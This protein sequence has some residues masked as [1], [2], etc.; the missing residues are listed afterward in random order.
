MQSVSSRIWTRVAVFI[1]YDNNHYTMGTSKGEQFSSLHLILSEYN[2]KV[3]MRKR[4]IL[5]SP[6]LQLMW[7]RKIQNVF[8][9]GGGGY[10]IEKYN[11]EGKYITGKFHAY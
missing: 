11:Y 4:K 6:P 3:E 10:I 1:S 2:K 5:F 7:Q 9:D 8:S